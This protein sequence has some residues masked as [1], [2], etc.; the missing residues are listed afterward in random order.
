MEGLWETDTGEF[1]KFSRGDESY[2]VYVAFEE[3]ESS[4]D[5]LS[6]NLRGNE[7]FVSYPAGA[8]DGSFNLTMSEDW[9]S[10]TYRDIE[11]TKK[12]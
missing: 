8:M 6:F 1:F 9:N 3:T 11:F 12:G 5:M 4:Y 2:E 10:F 7:L